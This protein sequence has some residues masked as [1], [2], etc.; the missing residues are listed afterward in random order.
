MP[1]RHP[2]RGAVGSGAVW[3]QWLSQQEEQR[4]PFPCPTGQISV[5]QPGM[6]QCQWWRRSLDGSHGLPCPCL[7]IQHSG[8]LLHVGEAMV[9][10]QCGGNAD[11]SV[12]AQGV[13]LQ[14]VGGRKVRKHQTGSH[15]HQEG[16][17]SVGM[18]VGKSHQLRFALLGAA[19]LA[20]LSLLLRGRSRKALS[21]SPR[22]AYLPLATYL[23]RR[24][25]R[26]TF[27]ALAIALAPATPMEF[28]RRL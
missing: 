18:G 2:Q 11:G 24:R 23:S 27:S 10:L 3:V 6:G 20:M 21:G 13:F 1:Q 9:A 4:V 8:H 5:G 15:G 12:H 22:G 14:A 17:H 7:T 16:M 28:P 25:L 26:F 19:G